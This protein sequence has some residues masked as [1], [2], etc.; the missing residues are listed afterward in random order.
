MSSVNLSKNVYPAVHNILKDSKFKDEEH[1][2]IDFSLMLAMSK[3]SEFEG[4]CR[5]FEEKYGM[6]FDEFEK[7]NQKVLADFNGE[8]S[9]FQN[10]IDLI[11]LYY[12]TSLIYPHMINPN[13]PDIK[14]TSFQEHILKLTRKH[15]NV[16]EPFHIST[17]L[18]LLL[19]HFI[20]TQI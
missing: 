10:Y 14:L 1:A 15:Q 3:R 2:L 7:K 13:P 20:F 4:E 9:I 5:V 8:I 6:G 19:S 12:N 18:N 17:L 11:D 16:R